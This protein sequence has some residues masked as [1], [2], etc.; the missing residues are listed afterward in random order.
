VNGTPAVPA[1]PWVRR[2]G[3][4]ALVLAALATGRAV[5]HAFPV[6]GRIEAPFVRTTG[7]GESLRLRYADVEAGVPAGG[8]EL[9]ARGSL[10]ST[11][12]VWVVVPVTITARAEPRTLA[13]AAVRG[14]DGTVYT[15]NGPA[16][17]GGFAPGT[18][19]PG[20][21]RYADVAVELPAD[22]AVGA[23]LLLALHSFDHRRDDLADIDLGVT[24]ADV[25]RW[26]A[27]TSPVTMRERS[28][29]P[30]SVA[31]GGGS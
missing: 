24:R 18:A 5:T 3:I 28:E 22:A 7:V 19:Q 29:T 9:E 8:G 16:S 20:I 15:A 1:R 4:A 11:P 10:L 26:T 17:R 12:G 21:P 13:Y 23:H 27:S 30:P 31:S 25:E 2:L 14:S 6:D